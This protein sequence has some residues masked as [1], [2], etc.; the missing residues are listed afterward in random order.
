MVSSSKIVFLVPML[1]TIL[2]SLHVTNG[3]YKHEG[4]FPTVEIMIRNNMSDDT[5][6][7]LHCKDKSHDD[8]FH[9]INSGEI[10]SFSAMYVPYVGNA[11]W[12]CRFTW[13]EYKWNREVRYFDIFIQ[14]R[15]VKH[16]P[17]HCNWSIN[18]S[19]PCRIT[20]T[21]FECFPWNS[22]DENNNALDV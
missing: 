16:C 18:Y 3:E 15:D 2:L 19:G 11:L 20:E 1:L 21:N 13:G 10:H 5:L 7:G 14:N 4:F 12:F 6:L 22:P 17:A 8:G 9:K